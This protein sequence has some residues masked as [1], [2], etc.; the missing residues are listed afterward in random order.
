MARHGPYHFHYWREYAEDEETRRLRKRYV[1][2][3]QVNAVRARIE[4]TK[5]EERRERE[6]DRAF[7]DWLRNVSA[8]LGEIRA[9]RRSRW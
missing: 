2:P 4:A 3:E 1:R 8:A 6:E 5:A 9:R 7:M